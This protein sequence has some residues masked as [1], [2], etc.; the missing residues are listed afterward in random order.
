M[1]DG[2]ARGEEISVQCHRFTGSSMTLGSV[3]RV[4]KW[5]WQDEEGQDLVEYGL[6]VSLVALACITSMK[7]LANAIS[8]VFS[9]AAANL[10]T[11]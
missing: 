8:V 4:L 11:S 1:F 5:L 6:L 9:T 2:V 3:V 10:T 7:S